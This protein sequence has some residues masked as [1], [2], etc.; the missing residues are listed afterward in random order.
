MFMRLKIKVLD[1][2]NLILVHILILRWINI[3]L[4]QLL[5]LEHL[6]KKE[7]RL[8]FIMLTIKQNKLLLLKNGGV[9]ICLSIFFS[10]IS[11]IAFNSFNIKMGLLE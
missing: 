9:I 6:I 7:N 10:K 1:Q 4:E 3:I 8:L 5:S 11:K 2:L